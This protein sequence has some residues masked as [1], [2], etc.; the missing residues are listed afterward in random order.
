MSRKKRDPLT[1]QKVRAPKIWRPAAID[2][3][4]VGEYV[5]RTLREGMFGQYEVVTIWVPGKG[6]FIASGTALIQLVDAAGLERGDPI[7]IVYRGIEELYEG[8]RKLKLFDL[9]VV[10]REV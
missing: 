3:E 1:W 4:L 8:E 9:Y 6:A 5:G 10:R 7:R 2:E